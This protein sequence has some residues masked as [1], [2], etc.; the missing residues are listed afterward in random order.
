MCS[1][2]AV[3][4]PEPGYWIC[5]N[6]CF[7]VTSTV[8]LVDPL[9]GEPVAGSAPSV[10]ANSAIRMTRGI[11]KP[12]AST[13][14]PKRRGS[15]ALGASRA[16]PRMSAVASSITTMQ[17]MTAAPMNMSHHA[18]T[19]VRAA[20]ECGSSVDWLPPQP[21][22]EALATSTA[23]SR[24]RPRRPVRLGRPMRYGSGRSARGGRCA[25]GRA[26]CRCGR[27]MRSSSPPPRAVK[28]VA[29]R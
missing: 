18:P 27:C 10:T 3:T 5:Q 12:P 11:A 26:A 9:G 16:R 15:P 22:S 19:I 28:P 6:H 24:T 1:S 20:W 14:T 21:A 29:P 23:A 4:T 25:T 13:S 2:F 8:I 7:P 17:K